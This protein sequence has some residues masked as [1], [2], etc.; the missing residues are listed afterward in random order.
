V[1]QSAHHRLSGMQNSPARTSLYGQIA[2]ENYWLD[3]QVP[4]NGKEYSPAN[5]RLNTSLQIHDKQN[6]V[7]R[8]GGFTPL[9]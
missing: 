4:A 1:E 9:L 8:A 6:Y 7:R 2:C 5:C 3:V